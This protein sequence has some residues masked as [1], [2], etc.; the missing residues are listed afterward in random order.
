MTD[1]GVPLS[2]A[3][4]MSS[5]AGQSRLEPS[6]SSSGGNMESPASSQHQHQVRVVICLQTSLAGFSFDSLL[7]CPCHILTYEIYQKHAGSS[8]ASTSCQSSVPQIQT[9]TVVDEDSE[10]T[11]HDREDEDNMDTM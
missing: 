3:V 11:D 10:D 1:S 9:F 5:S 2:Q 8:A 7:S 6:S 4:W